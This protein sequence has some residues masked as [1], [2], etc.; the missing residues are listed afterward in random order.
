MKC[1]FVL[2]VLV[3]AT[4]GKEQVVYKATGADLFDLIRGIPPKGGS[5]DLTKVEDADPASLP[6]GI[7]FVPEDVSLDDTE[8]TKLYVTKSNN[9]AVGPEKKPDFPVEA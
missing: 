6:D 2:L 9:K 7:Y 5:L 8:P 3:C 1:V 4:F